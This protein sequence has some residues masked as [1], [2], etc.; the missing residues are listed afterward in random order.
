MKMNKE[1]RI[2]VFPANGTILSGH[3]GRATHFVAYHVENG[4]IVKREI[5]KSPEHEHGS[6]PQFMAEIGA[7]DI[8]SGGMGPSAIDMLNRAGIN[9]CL[10]AKEIDVSSL[11]EDFLNGTLKL[12]K[13]ICDHGEGEHRHH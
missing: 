6:F 4:K 8:I 2:I 12:N 10:G 1:K 9:I 11:I 5:Y 7:T 3:F 13:N